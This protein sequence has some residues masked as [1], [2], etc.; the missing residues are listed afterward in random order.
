VNTPTFAT[1]SAGLPL[2][3]LWVLLAL[4]LM[5]KIWIITQTLYP[6]DT[7]I[8]DVLFGFPGYVNGLL[9]HGAFRACDHVPFPALHEGTCAYATRMP[10]LPMFLVGLSYLVGANM[11]SVAVAK[12]VLMTGLL[13]LAVYLWAR[14]SVV[15]WSSV[16]VVALVLFGPQV[17]KHAACNDYEEGLLVELMACHALLLGAILSRPKSWTANHTALVCVALVLLAGLGY[18]TKTTILP[19]LI[20]TIVFCLFELRSRPGVAASVAVLGALPLIAWAAF[21]LHS[22]GRLTISSSWNGE[23]LLRGFNSESYEIYPDISV[24]RIFDSREIILADG[25]VV[26][27]GQ[28]INRPSFADEW[29]W[30]DYYANLAKQWIAEN[31]LKAVMFSGKKAWAMF[32]DVQRVPRKTEAAEGTDSY[33]GR[34]QLAGIAW[35]SIARLLF[36]AFCVAALVDWR[37]RRTVD[38]LW[39]L[40]LVAAY[41]APY[42][43]VFASQRHAV[44]MLA[45]AGL[46]LAAAMSRTRSAAAEARSPGFG[47]GAVAAVH[48]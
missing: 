42:V 46:S 2:Q 18:L 4:A 31:P 6:G 27:A 24:D 47:A 22:T 33:G 40:L 29:Q 3:A 13:A 21:C 26:H 36:V 45:Y 1:R 8:R 5:A 34:A 16:L 48:T 19:F 41:S 43:V 9:D 39:P 12:A 7:T 15:S 23:N 38:A 37:R 30:N 28:W 25:R 35:M 14:S 32:V 11:A 20:M 10:A 44:P 17:L